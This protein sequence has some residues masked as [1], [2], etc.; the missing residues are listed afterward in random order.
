MRSNV[1]NLFRLNGGHIIKINNQ[2]ENNDVDDTSA[3]VDGDACGTKEL[4]L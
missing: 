4:L 1:I 2:K 3:E